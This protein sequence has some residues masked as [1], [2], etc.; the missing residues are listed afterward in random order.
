MKNLSLREAVKA[1]NV[2]RPT[3]TKSLN[4]GKLS[5][6]KNGKGQW[7]IS[8]SELARVY[9]PRSVNTEIREQAEQVNFTTKNTAQ[10]TEIERL[11][12]DLALA[13]ARAE[14]AEKLAQERAD[15]IEDLRRI[16]PSLATSEGASRP[17]GWWPW[18]RR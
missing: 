3:L 13:E 14:A 7:E 10:N 2:S 4:N 11:K 1:F 16:L 9:Q 8:P 6:V 12:A 15:R 18:R 5:G 17:R